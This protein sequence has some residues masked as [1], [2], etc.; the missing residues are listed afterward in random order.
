MFLVLKPAEHGNR[1][2]HAGNIKLAS[3]LN[4][5]AAELNKCH[6]TRKNHIRQKYQSIIGSVLSQREQSLCAP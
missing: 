5:V 6:A 4:V 2:G 3:K 1:Q